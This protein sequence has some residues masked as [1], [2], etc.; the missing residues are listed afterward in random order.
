MV[1]TDRK[2]ADRE[3]AVLLR[4]GASGRWRDGRG[5]WGERAV[6]A[7]AGWRLAPAKNKRRRQ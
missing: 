4:V 6:A 3:K 1:I 7:S 2:L 5:G